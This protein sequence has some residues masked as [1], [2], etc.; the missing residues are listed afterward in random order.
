M[1]MPMSKPMPKSKSMK[2]ARELWDAV[3]AAVE[4]EEHFAFY[5]L[6]DAELDIRTASQAKTGPKALA[7]MFTQ[8]RG[9]YSELAHAV[10]GTV[11]S[12]DGSALSVELVNVLTGSKDAAAAMKAAQAAMD[13][14]MQ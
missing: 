12:A 7:G 2:T 14:A 13:E 4:A 8:Q 9:L 11:E 6:C 10:E 3:Y 1:T 5:E